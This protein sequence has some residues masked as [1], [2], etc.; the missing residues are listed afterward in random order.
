MQLKELQLRRWQ[1]NDLL[2]GSVEFFSKEGSIKLNLRPEHITKIIAVVADAMVASA[3]SVANDMTAAIL[4]ENEQ[5]N[6]LEHKP[7]GS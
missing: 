2:E 1:S 6:L 5:I 4:Q 7:D 3:Q